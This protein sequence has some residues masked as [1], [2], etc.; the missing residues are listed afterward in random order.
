M[1]KILSEPDGGSAGRKFRKGEPGLPEQPG[2]GII[3]DGKRIRP[4]QAYSRSEIKPEAK[5]YKPMLNKARAEA[6]ARE[7]AISNRAS[8]MNE[9]GD[10]YKKGGAVKSASKRADGIVSKGKTRGTIVMCGGGMAGGKR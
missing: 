5:N 2:E 3:V 1:P 9:M 10:S 4:E 6:E 8:R 7:E